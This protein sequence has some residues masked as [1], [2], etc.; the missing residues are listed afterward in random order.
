MKHIARLAALMCMWVPAVAVH[1]RTNG[2]GD[3]DWSALTLRDVDAMHTL[4]RDNTPITFDKENP[5]YAHWL[6]EGHTIAQGR[7]AK[8][9]DE[10]GYLYT[11]NAYANGFRDPHF[12]VQLDLPAANRWPGFVAVERGETAVVVQRDADD[13][14]APAL[15]ARIERCDGQPLSALVRSRVLPFSATAGL[16]DRWAVHNLFLDQQNPFA[17]LP[18]S[19]VVRNG[20]DTTELPLRWRGIS[21]VDDRFGEEL[22]AEIFGSPATWGLSEPSPGV[23]WIGVPTFLPDEQA[24]PKM[25]A[26][27]AAIE[28]RGD[29]MR[30]ARAIIIDTRHN[31]G[32]LAFWAKQLADVIFTPKVLRNAGKAGPAQR[33][34]Y[35]KRASA[36]NLAFKR[37]KLQRISGDLSADQRRHAGMEIS[38]LEKALQRNIPMLH[39]GADSASASGGLTTQRP[40]N[41]KS[42]FP[43]KVF[44]LSNGSCLS[45]CLLFA[46][47]ALMVP[48]VK[49]IGS[50]TGADTPYMDIREEK[51]PS[52]FA[53]LSIA[54]TV[55]RGRGRGAMEAYAP[56]IAYNGSWDDSSIRA[57][58]LSLIP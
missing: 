22:T 38:D 43:A 46:D 1:A 18:A 36:G 4:L 41:A 44:F 37:E 57:W 34:A 8:V 20:A 27:I 50:A 17:Q 3:V 33:I 55:M 10:A 48:G 42:P 12:S 39:S 24:T 52:G 6:E 49:L 29:E 54:Q 26:L 13:P 16:P 2:S 31:S 30:K 5:S 14:A 15:G 25:R 32:G 45:A 7:A 35:D 21:G 9:T 53:T 56:D 58:T 40:R 47:Q 23:F 19:C 28:A 11:V 51:L